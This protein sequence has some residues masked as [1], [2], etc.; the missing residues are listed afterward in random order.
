[1]NIRIHESMEMETG[2]FMHCEHLRHGAV[3][4]IKQSETAV[5][6]CYAGASTVIDSC[7]YEELEERHGS[8]LF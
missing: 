2:G 8:Q 3:V 4:L 5:M 6:M 1:M 7:S